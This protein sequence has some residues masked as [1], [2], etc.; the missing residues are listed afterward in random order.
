MES[1]DKINKVI[2]T[3]SLDALETFTLLYL[4]P[5]E[6]I[7]N[8]S[9][10]WWS[11]YLKDDKKKHEIFAPYPWYQVDSSFAYLN[12]PELYYYNWTVIDCNSLQVFEF[13][14]KKYIRI[15]AENQFSNINQLITDSLFGP[16]FIISMNSRSDR[17]YVANHILANI[18]IQANR[19]PAVDQQVIDQWGGKKGLQEKMVVAKKEELPNTQTLGCTLS[20]YC[21]WVIG[22]TNAKTDIVTIFEDDI[23]SYISQEALH[24]KVQKA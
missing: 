1:I 5:H 7:T 6:I 22:L 10:S 24:D 20:H 3:D 15:I 21:A 19:F 11:A 9:F 12:I 8:S 4:C 13:P 14:I 2:Y 16:T 18:G 17:Y 23:T